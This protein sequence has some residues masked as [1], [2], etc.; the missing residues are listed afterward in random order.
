[1]QLKLVR[2]MVPDEKARYKVWKREHSSFYDRLGTVLGL[3]IALTLWTAC[4]VI[5]AAS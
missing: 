5:W 2:G 1:M 4:W 3:A